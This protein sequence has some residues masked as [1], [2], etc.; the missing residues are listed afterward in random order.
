[1][2]RLIA[3]NGPGDRLVHWR[4]KSRFQNA[5]ALLPEGFGNRIYALL[6][7]RFGGLRDSSP[8]SRLEAAAG[9]AGRTVSPPACVNG[10][11]FLEVGTGHSVSLPVGLWLCGARAVTTV[12]LN[13]YL[14]SDLVRADIEYI[15]THVE[16]VASILA[17][18]SAGATLCSRIDTLRGMSGMPLHELLETMGI[19]YLAPAD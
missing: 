19:Q 10:T 18:H 17:S 8:I 5:I 1:G 16:D 3:V 12:D 15:I 6:Q 9:V 2:D 11:S 14:Q 7:R 13:S 4:T